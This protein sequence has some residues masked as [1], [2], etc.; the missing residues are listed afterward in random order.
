MIREYGT[1]RGI[2]TDKDSFDFDDHKK[3]IL[4]YSIKDPLRYVSSSDISTIKGKGGYDIAVLDLGMKNNIIKELLKR[5]HSV[6][7]IRRHQMQMIS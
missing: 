3:E 1:M 2:I 6:L 4:S 5:G 7:F